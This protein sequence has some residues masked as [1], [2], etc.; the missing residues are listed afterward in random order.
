MA[1]CVAGGGMLSDA[2]TAAE[3]QST[4][5]HC[6]H[7]FFVDVALLRDFIPAAA[8]AA[9]AA[10]S[11]AVGEVCSSLTD[12]QLSAVACIEARSSALTLIIARYL[13]PPPHT[14]MIRMLLICAVSLKHD[15]PT[16]R[17]VRRRAWQIGRFNA[18][19]RTFMLYFVMCSFFELL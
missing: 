6:R 17:Q 4:S 5:T 12:T 15:G 11:A 19:N 8:A 2:A 3:T 9:A 10:G 18:V 16:G 1:G 13:Y 7:A 14:V